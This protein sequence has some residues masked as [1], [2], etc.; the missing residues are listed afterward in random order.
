[1]FAGTSRFDRSVQC[2]HVCLVGNLFDDRDLLRDR[3]HRGNGFLNRLA[4]LSGVLRSLACH[5]LHLSAVFS[6]LRDGSA[7]LFHAA[8]H[9]FDCGCLLTGALRDDAGGGS[10]LRGGRAYRSGA[11]AHFADHFVELA[12]HLSHGP[13]QAAE[14]IAAIRVDGL[15]QI[16]GADVLDDFEHILDRFG[17]AA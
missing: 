13:K 10:H 1:M 12:G 16:S 8:G 2:Q 6:V 17:N 5:L 3:L 9:L 14:L 4:T 11:H 7:H 15:G